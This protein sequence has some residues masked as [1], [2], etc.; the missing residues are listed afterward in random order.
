[1]GFIQE[2]DIKFVSYLLTGVGRIKIKELIF[3][4]EIE[5]ILVE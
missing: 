5:D 3:S 2:L 1:M 4:T